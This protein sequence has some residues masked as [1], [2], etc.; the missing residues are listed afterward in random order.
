[1]DRPKL[2]FIGIG[3]VG[4]ALARAAAKAGFPVVAVSSRR[5]DRRDA[6]ARD[7]QTAVAANTPQAVADRADVVLLTVPDDAI[8]PV[9]E[10]IRWREGQAVVHCN[11]AS[12]LAPLNAAAEQG[13]A[14]GVFHPLQSLA[15]DAEAEARIPGSPVG[16]E[17]SSD[18]L[19]ETLTGLAEALGAT[20]LVLRGDAAIYH[21]SAVIASNYLVALL[22]AAAGLWEHLGLTKAEG[23]EALLPLVRGT[24]EN[25]GT[26]GLPDALTGPIARGD[27]GTIERHLDAL[28]RIAPDVLPLYREMARRTIPIAV[29]KRTI[30]E[31]AAARLRREVQQVEAG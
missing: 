15:T 11:G 31:A 2:G 4:N 28:T 3:V 21:A 16:I 27:V 7:L 5:A 12:S 13:A 14:I 22:D 8:R 6:L 18:D 1:V 30:D 10:S 26:V 20:P 25:L 17:A 24:V 9:T 29:E 23:L 19:A